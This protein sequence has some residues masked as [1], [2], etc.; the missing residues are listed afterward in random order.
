M[1]GKRVQFDCGI[2]L[3]L[4]VLARGRVPRISIPSVPTLLAMTHFESW[5]AVLGTFVGLSIIQFVVGN[6]I[7][8]RAAGTVLSVSPMVV[9]FAIFF[10]TFL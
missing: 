9:L 3:A 7:E 8:P 1:D 4:D 2:W 10:G 5:Q 6:Y